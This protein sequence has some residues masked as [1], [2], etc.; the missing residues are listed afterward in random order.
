[1][2]ELRKRV[3]VRV[4]ERYQLRKKL[5]IVEVCHTAS[6]ARAEMY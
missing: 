1:M 6:A 3:V 2:N 4:E 5:N